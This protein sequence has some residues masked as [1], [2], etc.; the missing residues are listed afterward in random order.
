MPALSEA[1]AELADPVDFNLDEA[2]RW[3]R[4]DADRCAA[5]DDVTGMER[6]VERNQADQLLDRKA[7]VADSTVR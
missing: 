4:A 2:D 3:H 7:H 6:H 1:V 5:Q